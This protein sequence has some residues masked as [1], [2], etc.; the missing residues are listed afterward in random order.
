MSD[1]GSMLYG[2]WCQL[3]EPERAEV[4]R[5]VVLELEAEGHLVR[6]PGDVWQSAAG[7]AGQ[8][9]FAYLRRWR[10]VRSLARLTRPRGSTA[11]DSAARFLALVALRSETRR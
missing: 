5:L 11:A 7:F 8:M 3:P 6:H 1:V 2:D 10:R 9:L 4:V